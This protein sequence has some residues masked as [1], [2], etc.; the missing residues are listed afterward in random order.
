MR[1]SAGSCGG[2]RG[3]GTPSRSS[4][5]AQPPRRGIFTSGSS[6]LAAFARVPDAR[7]R[8]GR[9]YPLPA[10][11]PLA[12]AAMLAATLASAVVAAG[13]TYLGVANLLL[14]AF[15][16]IPGFPLDGG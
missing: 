6:L 9:R 13:L 10:V 1:S 7:S 5:P 11:L 15:N 16:L 3:W 12:P 14:G 4:P 2:S 8:H